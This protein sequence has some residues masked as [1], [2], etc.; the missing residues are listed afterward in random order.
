MFTKVVISKVAGNN[1][2]NP[3]NVMFFLPAVRDSMD[4]N[5]KISG[6]LGVLVTVLIHN[7]YL[8]DSSTAYFWGDVSITLACEDATS[9]HTISDATI[10]YFAPR[11]QCRSSETC[12]QFEPFAHNFLTDAVLRCSA[13]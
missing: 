1:I 11:L 2:T 12:A 6:L 3:V 9:V 4:L 10:P 13:G 8:E 7:F 5:M